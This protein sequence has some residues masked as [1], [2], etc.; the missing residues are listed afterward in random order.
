MFRSVLAPGLQKGELIQ[1]RSLVTGVDD[2]GDENV[3]RAVWGGRLERPRLPTPASDVCSRACAVVFLC[4]RKPK[5]TPKTRPETECLSNGAV[6]VARLHTVLKSTTASPVRACTS[7]V[8]GGSLAT[9]T[10][11]RGI[12]TRQPWV[13][14]LVVSYSQ[15]CPS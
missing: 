6:S 8:V 7:V 2:P 4:H 15:P 12:R 10:C 5:P 3:W 11:C 9:F 1:G 14:E 13:D